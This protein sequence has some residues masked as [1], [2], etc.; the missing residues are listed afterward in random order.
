MQRAQ[1]S[2]AVNLETYMDATAAM[3]GLPLQPEHR[4]GVLRY[5]QMVSSFVPRV[6]EFAATLGPEDESGNT[7]KPVA[8]APRSQP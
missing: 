2:P 5:L 6:T 1:P 4:P 8:P 7:F 3:L